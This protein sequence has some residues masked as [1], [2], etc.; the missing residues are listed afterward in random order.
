VTDSALRTA[1][2]A[3]ELTNDLCGAGVKPDLAYNPPIRILVVDDELLARRAL[4]GALQ[5]AFSQPACAES[6]RMA[7]SLAAQMEFDLVFLDVGMPEIDGFAVC[8]RIHETPLNRLTP[9]VFVT[10][11][12]DEEFR[13]RSVQCGGCDFVA[14]PFA[15]VE[16]AVKALTLSLRGRLEKLKQTPAPATAALG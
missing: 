7:L 15:F 2:T 4:S 13:A 11:H 8:A 9:V 6:P 10:G 3:L 12:S 14:K 1:T 16:V 5:L